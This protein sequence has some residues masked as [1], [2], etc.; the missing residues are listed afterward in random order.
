MYIRHWKDCPIFVTH[1]KL[2]DWQIFTR[3]KGDT[4][5]K[6][7]GEVMINLNHY[8]R[9]VLIDGSSTEPTVHK[10]E[11]EFMHIVAG[12]GVLKVGNEEAE[13]R[14]GS[15]FQIPVWMEHV[16]INT[17]S[18]DLEMLTMRCAPHPDGRN[19]K[20]IVRNWREPGGGGKGHWNHLY[21][22]PHV[23]IH[24]GSI[25]PRKIS[26]P[27]FH[28]PEHDEIWYIAKGQGWHW[29]G[30]EL[31]PQ[32][33]GWALWLVPTETHSLINPSDETIEYLYV[34]SER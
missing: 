30:E 28:D 11:V 31:H 29:M 1:G 32:G 17:Q 21:K 33:S 14:D 7:T 34:A 2:R 3:R 10:D 27:H 4:P 18:E 16:L 20:F 6:E 12:K 9:A 24:A 8:S 26:H 15:S 5:N 22:G 19:A 23:R 25:A 13:I